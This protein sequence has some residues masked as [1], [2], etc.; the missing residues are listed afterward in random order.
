VASAEWITLCSDLIGTGETGQKLI[1]LSFK[2]RLLKSRKGIHYKQRIDL[3]I[4]A[5]G[6][7]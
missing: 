2:N 6:D 5:T 3:T 7:P 1:V 4:Y